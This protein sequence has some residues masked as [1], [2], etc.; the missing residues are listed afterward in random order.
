MSDS[1]RFEIRPAFVEAEQRHAMECGSDPR[2]RNRPAE[3][4]AQGKLD[5]RRGVGPKGRGNFFF[6]HDPYPDAMELFAS[7]PQEHAKLASFGSTKVTG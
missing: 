4:S 6:E 7:A 1:K 5:S 2:T 3:A